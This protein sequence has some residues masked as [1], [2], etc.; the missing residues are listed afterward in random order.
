MINI[1]LNEPMTTIRRGCWVET[2]WGK[3]VCTE[4]T[5]PR[6]ILE[7]GSSPP[8]ES[9]VFRPIV[10]YRYES[11]RNTPEEET[12][13]VMNGDPAAEA[14]DDPAW[15]VQYNGPPDDTSHHVLT[16]KGPYGAGT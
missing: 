6:A 13:W 12:I 11:T 5:E 2:Q 14:A 8:K 7:E 3:A 15:F 16:L 10:F 9:S 1:P 4:I